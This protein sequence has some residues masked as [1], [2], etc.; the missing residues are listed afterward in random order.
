MNQYYNSWAT[1]QNKKMKQPPPPLLL[2]CHHWLEFIAY[3]FR[4]GPCGKLLFTASLHKLNISILMHPNPHFVD[5]VIAFSM[6]FLIWFP[7]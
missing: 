1:L 3:F 6:E 7:L 2:L 4:T 5:Q